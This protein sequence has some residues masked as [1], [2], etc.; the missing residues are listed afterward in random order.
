MISMKITKRTILE[1]TVSMITISLA[2][3]L[4]WF[5]W[6]AVTTGGPNWSLTMTWNIYGEGIPEMAVM[7]L[8]LFV[9]IIHLYLVCRDA[10][11]KP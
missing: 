3:N 10:D 2:I 5:M 7:I 9:G 4:L 11:I 8:F 1:L 6:L